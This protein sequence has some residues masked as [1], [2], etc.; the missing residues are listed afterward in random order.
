MTNELKPDS[1]SIYA[2][3]DRIA[4][5]TE[6][7]VAKSVCGGPSGDRCGEILL[8]RKVV[9]EKDVIGD[10]KYDGNQTHFNASPNQSNFQYDEANCIEYLTEV[11]NS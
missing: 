8:K 7:G 5:T 6:V 11:P 10:G 2:M 4:G 1:A 3:W 9:L